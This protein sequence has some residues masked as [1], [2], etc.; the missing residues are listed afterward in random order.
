MIQSTSIT[1]SF[2]PKIGFEFDSSCM[3]KSIVIVEDPVYRAASPKG[4]KGRRWQSRAIGQG[5]V[6][7]PSRSPAPCGLP[8]STTWVVEAP[9]SVYPTR[10]KTPSVFINTV[11]IRPSQKLAIFYSKLLREKTLKGGFVLDSFRLCAAV[12]P[13]IL[14]INLSTLEILQAPTYR[15]VYLQQW[16]GQNHI[17]VLW[18][19]RRQDAIA[20]PSTLRVAHFDDVSH[21][22]IQPD[23][24]K[25]TL[26]PNLVERTFLCA[27][28]LDVAGQ[29]ETRSERLGFRSPSGGFVLD[30]FS[31]TLR[32]S[33]SETPSV[34]LGA[35]MP[36]IFAGRDWKGGFDLDSFS[37]MPSVILG[38]VVHCRK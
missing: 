34:L 23:S 21:R 29:E 8:T 25:E 26:P 20:F 5:V 2:A 9:R 22:S 4:T 7:T 27:F 35:E 16:T 33:G 19:R 18:A 38:A 37:K 3:Q 6:K 15:V 36:S 12:S 11:G 28:L 14:E 13:R 24:P 10:S 31:Q 17:A 30:L 1:D 32:I